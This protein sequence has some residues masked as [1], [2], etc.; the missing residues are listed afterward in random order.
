MVFIFKKK[1]KK[2]LSHGRVGPQEVSR[3]VH[4]KEDE[5]ERRENSK[6]DQTNKNF[7]SWQ[8]SEELKRC[9][10]DEGRKNSGFNRRHQELEA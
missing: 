9:P 2:N 3:V 5:D 8:R 4:T 1:R 7:N 6:N 10:E